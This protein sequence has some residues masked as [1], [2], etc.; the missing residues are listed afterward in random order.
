MQKIVSCRKCTP[1]ASQKP[2]FVNNSKQPLH[3]NYFLKKIDILKEDYQKLFLT[4]L[5][6][7]SP[8]L[9]KPLHEMKNYSFTFHFEFAKCGKKGKNYKHWNIL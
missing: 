4:Y 1:K 2:L 5:K 6:N 3:A 7:T 9:C 8:N